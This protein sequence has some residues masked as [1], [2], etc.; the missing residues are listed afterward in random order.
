MA[1][2]AI[3]HRVGKP[4]LVRELLAS[5]LPDLDDIETE[6][7]AQAQDIASDEIAST[8]LS[9]SVR[10]VHEYLALFYCSFQPQDATGADEFI[11]QNKD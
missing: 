7:P 5:A 11:R 10:E 3:A 2:T 9:R 8:I 4:A 1:A 6:P